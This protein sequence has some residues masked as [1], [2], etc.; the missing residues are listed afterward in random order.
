MKFYQVNIIILVLV[1]GF[2]GDVEWKTMG[3]LLIAAI[4]LASGVRYYR[5][6]V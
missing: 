6:D 1:L 2:A 4:Q 3:Y 5:E